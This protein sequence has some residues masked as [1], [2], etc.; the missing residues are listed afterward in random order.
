MGQ[1]IIVNAPKTFTWVWGIVKPW[2]AHETV[3][4]VIILGNNYHDTLLGI[5]DPESLPATLGGT[6]RCHLSHAGPWL[7]GRARSCL[8]KEGHLCPAEDVR[9][10]KAIE[11]ADV[12]GEAKLHIEQEVS[13]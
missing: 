9:E 1:V 11:D 10:E 5:A 2:L 12:N 4:K 6:C 7:E 8:D 13:S 3:E